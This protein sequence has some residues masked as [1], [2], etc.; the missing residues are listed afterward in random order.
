MPTAVSNANMRDVA[1]DFDSPTTRRKYL[2]A[3]GLFSALFL[4]SAIFGLLDID[5]S[6]AEW[7]HLGY[8]LWTF[9]ALTIAKVVGIAAILS[10]RSTRLKQFA[11]AGFL[12]DLLLALG[13][14]IAQPEVKLILP[15]SCLGIWGFAY[16]MDSRVFPK[17]IV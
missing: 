4:G 8:P 11:F 15:L 12:Y 17:S 2:I 1:I 5:A 10:N 14:H 16:F 7:R 3:M 6:Y 9:Y 13:S